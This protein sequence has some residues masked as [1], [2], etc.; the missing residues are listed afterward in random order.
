MLKHYEYYFLTTFPKINK[1]VNY[2]VSAVSAKLVAMIFEAPLTLLKTR[3]E[4]ISSKNIMEEFNMILKNPMRDSLRG[5]GS[6]LT[7]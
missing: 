2:S 4:R 5:L 3:V 6:T 7:R 1:Y